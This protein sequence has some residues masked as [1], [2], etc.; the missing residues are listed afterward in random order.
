MS[1]HFSAAMLKLP[2][3]RMGGLIGPE[4]GLEHLDIGVLGIVI[5]A[6]FVLTWFVAYVTWHLARE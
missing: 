4:L 5:F 3:I 1:N 6:S 2:R